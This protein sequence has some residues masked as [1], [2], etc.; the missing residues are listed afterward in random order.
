M[1]TPWRQHPAVDDLCGPVADDD[2]APHVDLL[3]EKVPEIGKDHCFILPGP[4]R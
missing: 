2:D 4:R 3:F 1:V